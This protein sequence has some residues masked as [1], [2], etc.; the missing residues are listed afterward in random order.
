VPSGRE[1]GAARIFLERF[2]SFRGRSEIFGT[3]PNFLGRL[4]GFSGPFRS[5]LAGFGASAGQSTA[6]GGFDLTKLLPAGRESFRYT[7]SLTTPPFTEGVQFVVL[8]DSARVSKGQIEA[9]MSLFPEGNTREPQPLNGRTVL[10][11]IDPE[12]EQN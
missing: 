1:R 12:D 8:A 10:S 2:K 7:G 11:D 6:V 3:V 9:F 5:A 4:P